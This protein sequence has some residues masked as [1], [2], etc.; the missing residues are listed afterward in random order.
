VVAWYLATQAASS[1]GVRIIRAALDM[2]ALMGVGAASSTLRL[3]LNSEQTR[4]DKEGDDFDGK[5]R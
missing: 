3:W 5:T 1:A 4:Q 2:S